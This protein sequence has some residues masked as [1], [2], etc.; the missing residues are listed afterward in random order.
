MG[1]IARGFEQALFEAGD[2][3]KAASMFRD[4]DGE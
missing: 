3:L 4:R 1:V 2:L